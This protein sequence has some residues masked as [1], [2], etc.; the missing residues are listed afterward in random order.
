[1][2]IDIKESSVTD[3]L[4]EVSGF[5][6][7]PIPATTLTLFCTLAYL[8]YLYLKS[9]RTSIQH[10][11]K[12]SPNNSSSDVLLLESQRFHL[13]VL[14]KRH[15]LVCKIFTQLN[16]HFGFFLVMEI[17]YIFVGVINSSM[18]LLLG[19][20]NVGRL[21][22]ALFAIRFIDQI[23][24]LSLLTFIAEEINN[25]VIKNYFLTWP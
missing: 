16:R 8:V 17:I 2:N 11:L 14:E 10:L 23:A 1:M 18:N 6:A 20:G 3:L 12:T 25:E 13:N 21:M 7:R 19:G 22:E 4:I 5:I 24:H 9:I 15:L